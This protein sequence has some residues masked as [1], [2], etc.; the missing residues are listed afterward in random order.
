M[1]IVVDTNVIASGVFF[2]GKPRQLLELLFQRKIEVFAS[3]KIL[4]EYQETFDYLKEKYPD[5]PVN[6]PVAQI[7]LA[8]KVIEP[9][10]NLQ[11]CRDPDDDKFI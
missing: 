3:H 2:G 6:I 4:L 9:V 8:C 5:R 10:S 7:A 11:V 1:R